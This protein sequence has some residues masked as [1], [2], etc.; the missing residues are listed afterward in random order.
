MEE[1]ADL[2][3]RSEAELVLIHVFEPPEAPTDMPPPPE[4]LK[5]TRTDLERKLE[6]WKS[7][8]VRL[9]GR[10]VAAEVVEGSAADEISRAAQERGVDL[11]V[12]GTHGRRGL[13]HLLIGSVAERLVRVAHCPVLV[14][15]RRG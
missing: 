4:S 8:A 10:P 7:E 5:A 15:R 3:S 1:A 9:S 12:V 14:V 11:L 2:A 6:G 13:R